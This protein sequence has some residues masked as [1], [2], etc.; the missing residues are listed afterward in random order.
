MTSSFCK[1]H[2]ARLGG[3]AAFDF[4]VDGRRDSTGCLFPCLFF[5]ALLSVVSP[6]GVLLSKTF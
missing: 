2:S 5:L 1:G 3:R 4:L 6:F